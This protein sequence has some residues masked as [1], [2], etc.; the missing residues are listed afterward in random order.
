MALIAV[1]ANNGDIGGGEVMQLNLAEAARDLGHQ[2]TVVGPDDPSE[3]I[4]L[5]RRRG[6]ATRALSG[7]GRKTYIPALRGWSR[8]SSYDVIWAN[9]L[10]PSL[11]TAG[12]PGRV[13][14]LH[15]LPDSRAQQI[16][17]RIAVRRARAVLVPSAFMAEQIRTWH[18]SVKVLP[19]WTIDL[20]PVTG[21]SDQGPLRVGFLGRVTRDKGIHI[22]ADALAQ[23][24]EVGGREVRLVIGGER[25]FADPDPMVEAALGR[26]A[27]RTD[28]LGWVEREEFFSQVHLAA[29]PSVWPEPFGLVAAEAM[30]SA[31]PFVI[32]DAGALPE[33]V[34]PGYPWIARADDAAALAEVIR[35]ALTDSARRLHTVASSRQRWHDEYSPSAGRARLEELLLQIGVGT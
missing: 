18:A 15:R 2:V 23:L 17:A 21:P 20:A 34:G 13:V 11:A 5:A 10:V 6:F 8:T 32:S 29:F 31:V 35:Q 24:P 27:D 33:V 3:L 9:G 4:N 28:H 30:G 14:H 12:R 26:I 19:N 16:A 22:L 7:G 1:C 25:R